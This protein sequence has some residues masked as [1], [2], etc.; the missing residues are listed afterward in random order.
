MYS[1]PA[2]V[3]Y[4]LKAPE[5]SFQNPHVLTIPY[6]EVTPPLMLKLYNSFTHISWG[7]WGSPDYKYEHVVLKLNADLL[8]ALLATTEIK[9]LQ[10]DWLTFVLDGIKRSPIKTL[11][12]DASGIKF[13]STSTA[14]AGAGASSHLVKAS[15]ATFSSPSSTRTRA[16][17]TSPSPTS[18][19]TTEDFKTFIDSLDTVNREPSVYPV[20]ASLDISNCNL[21]PDD[22]LYAVSNC[23]SSFYRAL[24]NK[25]NP[26]ASTFKTPEIV[27]RELLVF[28][29]PALI[30]NEPTTPSEERK[31]FTTS[32]T[33]STTIIPS[34]IYENPFVPIVT[35]H[36]Y[37]PFKYIGVVFID[38]STYNEA[39][40]PKPIYPRDSMGN[41][42]IV[43]CNTIKSSGPILTKEHILLLISQ[44]TRPDPR[45]TPEETLLLA[46]FQDEA[47]IRAD[48]PA[49]MESHKKILEEKTKAEKIAKKTDTLVETVKSALENAKSKK[50]RDLTNEEI[51]Q[52]Y[53][54]LSRACV[55]NTLNET[56]VPR[57]L[58]LTI[59]AAVT[60]AKLAETSAI[61]SANETAA[62]ARRN[63][64]AKLRKAEKARFES[65]KIEEIR[66]N[67]ITPP[68]KSSAATMI[69]KSTTE[70]SSPKLAPKAAPAPTPASPSV[71][72]PVVAQAHYGSFGQATGA[73]VGSG[74]GPTLPG[75]A[76][77][78]TLPDQSKAGGI[79]SV[80]RKLP[81][82]EANE[83][84]KPLLEEQRAAKQTSAGAGTGAAKVK[85]AAQ[86]RRPRLNFDIIATDDYGNPILD[87]KGNP[88]KLVP[89][90]CPTSFYDKHTGGLCFPGC[91]PLEPEYQE[92][93][94][95]KSTAEDDA[96]TGASKG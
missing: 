71:E 85:D 47:R 19:L 6:D 74:L 22:L 1:S 62:E 66:R 50:R 81:R 92:A 86:P 95:Y 42:S 83:A 65:Q 44:Y 70:T 18:T 88:V 67:L 16:S 26:S 75:A 23:L 10:K 9:G 31:K 36:G 25:G 79:A 96:A 57:A 56:W 78:P 41:F 38:E 49:L 14:E 12:V 32:T 84:S 77:K 29:V 3:M 43:A 63:D 76:P 48:K 91:C 69:D 7:G 93:L 46:K 11:R 90:T 39:M 4:N 64:A 73:T 20:L 30:E 68:A 58:K 45:N 40:K 60:R 53:L 8:K 52:V 59:E 80:I 33:D 35:S 24:G 94:R 15:T 37:P 2:P 82:I 89:L 21:T 34:K 61:E 87:A 27:N 54:K 13:K 55:F 72:S 17:V 5:G 28:Q 51:D